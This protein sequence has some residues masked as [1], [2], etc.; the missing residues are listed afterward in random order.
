MIHF[1]LPLQVLPL[2]V[3][4]RHCRRLRHDRDGPSVPAGTTP[5]DP[6]CL[7]IFLAGLPLCVPLFLFVVFFRLD[8]VRRL[9]DG[10]AAARKQ[11]PLLP[12]I[13]LLHHRFNLWFR[14]R[15]WL[16]DVLL[17]SIDLEWNAYVSK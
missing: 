1:G 5:P 9:G 12:R 14:H 3:F 6:N 8:G 2:T 17:D 16:L 7:R 10:T 15:D 13:L 4:L 11:T